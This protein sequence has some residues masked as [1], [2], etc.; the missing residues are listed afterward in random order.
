MAFC[1]DGRYVLTGSGDGTAYL[2]ELPA[3]R[4][5]EIPVKRDDPDLKFSADRRL[6]WR[7]RGDKT[8]EIVETAT[9]KSLGLLAHSVPVQEAW[10]SPDSKTLVVEAS[11]RH[12]GPGEFRLWDTTA[13]T[14]I[15]TP[16]RHREGLTNATFSPDSK[17]VLLTWE[18]MDEKIGGFRLAHIDTGKSRDG[19]MPAGGQSLRRVVQSGQPT[20]GSV[21]V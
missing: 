6:A 13:A 4:L 9:D 18:H 8:I 2:W 12:L 20:P 19:A 21:L 10:F 15:G 17:S 11:N 1:P 16:F 5:Q 14:P 3:G 7:H